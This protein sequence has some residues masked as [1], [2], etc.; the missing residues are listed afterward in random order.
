MISARR[1]KN[2]PLLRFPAQFFLMFAMQAP[3]LFTAALYSPIDVGHVGLAMTAL[4][5]PFMLVGQAATKAY[6]AEIASLGKS[7]PAEIRK[8]ANDLT[9]YLF[10]FSLPIT[11]IIFF[12]G[13][14][15]F[16]VAFGAPW[17]PAGQLAS[18]LSIFLLFQFCA[19]PLLSVFNVFEAHYRVLVLHA[20]RAL[21]VTLAFCFAVFW[22]MEIRDAILTY[23]VFLSVHYLLMIAQIHRFLYLEGKSSQFKL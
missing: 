7:K 9:K 11:L 1:H 19:S 5:L 14:Q 16:T 8:L 12:F 23:A 10:T 22:D 2:I 6:Y 3:A 20:Q 21:L 4:A 18:T 13:E 15:M 17:G